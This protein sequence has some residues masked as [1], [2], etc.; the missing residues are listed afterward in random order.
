MKTIEGLTERLHQAAL[1]LDAYAEQIISPR[2]LHDRLKAEA[3][4]VKT[5]ATI[6][7]AIEELRGAPAS[8]DSVTIT[9]ANDDGDDHV[10]CLGEWT[11]VQ[12][13]EFSG[14]HAYDALNLA[15]ATKRLRGNF[16]ST[17]TPKSHD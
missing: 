6:L 17:S 5:A 3:D 10:I 15:A 16:H 7:E 2:Q 14:R 12:E 9:C 1:R 13:E 8:G 11:G 4:A